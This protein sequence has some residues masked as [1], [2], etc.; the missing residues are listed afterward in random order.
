M[1][2]VGLDF[3]TYVSREII[4][5][6][7]SQRGKILR[8]QLILSGV[9]YLI[10]IPCVFAILIPFSQWPSILL[11]C[12]LPI[13]FLEHIN[14][15]GYR[16]LVV[17]EEQVTASVALFSR[18]GLLAL[19][20]VFLMT[21]IPAFRHLEIV[22]VLWIISG[23]L[24]ALF[25]VWR[26]RVLQ[27]HGWKLPTDWRWI[28]RGVAVS[29]TFLIGTLALRG[30]LTFDRY[31]LE[32]LGG[33]KIVAAYVLFSGVASAMLTF[34]DSGVFAFA[35]PK[36]IIHHQNKDLKNAWIIMRRMIIMTVIISAIYAILSSLLMP[37]FLLL[38]NN[39]FYSENVYLYP[40]LLSATIINAFGMIPHFCLYAA[41]KDKLIVKANIVTLITFL[42]VAFLLVDYFHE[43]AIP[44]A[45]NFAFF[46]LLIFNTL[47]Y[48]ITIRFEK[49]RL[50]P[51]GI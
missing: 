30:M 43:L 37:Y 24:A 22:M 15:E 26:I 13:L 35:Y 14:Q 32:A 38:I 33:V 44:I 8:A 3:Y 12:F 28:K 1:Y 39:S 47:A 31:W 50:T 17:L 7:P 36:L 23:S 11:F 20:V 25:T 18:Q 49:D 48:L 6:P 19:S 51:I 45:L 29:L 34:L 2:F 4:K 42:I 27:F 40:W 10:Y 46:S 21:V 41:G 5:T 16:L 9:L